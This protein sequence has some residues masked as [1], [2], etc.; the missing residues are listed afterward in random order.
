LPAGLAAAIGSYR[1]L[2]GK[3]AAPIG[4]CREGEVLEL[5]TNWILEMG[6]KSPIRST[7]REGGTGF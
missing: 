4:S 5:Q 3:V 7:S 6:V 1:Q 2:V